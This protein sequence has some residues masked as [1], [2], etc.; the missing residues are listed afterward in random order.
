MKYVQTCDSQTHT[1]SLQQ[2]IADKMESFPPA[3]KKHKQGPKIVSV[4][5]R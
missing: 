2:D 1:D 3:P 4:T 5:A